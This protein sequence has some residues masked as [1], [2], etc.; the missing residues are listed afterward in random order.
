[1]KQVRV[2]VGVFVVKPNG[3]FFVCKRQGSHGEGSWSIPGG[4]LEF[5]ETW[6]DCARRE[7]KEETNIDIASKIE[8][9]GATNDIFTHEDKHYITIYVKAQW[10][11]VEPVQME[12]QKGGDWVWC[13]LETIPQPV[14]LPMQH[15]LEQSINLEIEK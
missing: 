11:G 7:V 9:V 8:F 4:H 15:V 6:E 5:G 1:M 14:F 10:P 12:P 2:G 3:E 13:T